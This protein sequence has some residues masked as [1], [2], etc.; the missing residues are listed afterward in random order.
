MGAIASAL[1]LFAVLTAA[2]L[3]WLVMGDEHD[4]TW[5]VAGVG[6]V[7]AAAFAWAIGHAD[8]LVPALRR[9]GTGR[10]WLVATALVPIAAMLAYAW[11]AG[12]AHLL[13]DVPVELSAPPLEL[14][15]AM[16]AVA[17]AEEVAYRGVIF[18]TVEAAFDGRTAVV[19]STALFALAHLM[20]LDLPVAVPMGLALGWLRLRSGSLMPGLAVRLTFGLA[21]VS[22]I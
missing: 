12:L 13:G 22:W 9:V 6:V 2:P 18:G 1:G 4:V 15:L 5:A 17:L 21:V 10:D 14:V 11:C 3:P 7:V 8:A 19:L 20:F 16:A